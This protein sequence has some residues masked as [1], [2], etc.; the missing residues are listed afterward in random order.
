MKC[1]ALVCCLLVL[2]LNVT[3]QALPNGVRSESDAS[4]VVDASPYNIL[5]LSISCRRCYIFNRHLNT[6]VPNMRCMF[7]DRRRGRH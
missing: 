3:A 6:C 2:S 7:R 1:S 5:G 4:R